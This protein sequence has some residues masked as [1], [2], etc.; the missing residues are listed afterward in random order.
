MPGAARPVGASATP[1][2]ARTARRFVR[3]TESNHRLPVAE[4]VLGRDFSPARPNAAWG[5]DITYVPTWTGFLYLA[6]VLDACTRR[7]VGWAMAVPAPVRLVTSTRAIAPVT[8][9]TREVTPRN[10]TRPP[11]RA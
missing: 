5:A 4:N 3:T 11:A 8:L 7:V 6:V 2:R 10:T 9:S 1:V